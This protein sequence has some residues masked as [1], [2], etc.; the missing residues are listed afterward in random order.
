[1]TL[2]SWVFNF[3]FSLRNKKEITKSILQ[4]CLARFWCTYRNWLMKTWESLMV[5]PATSAITRNIKLR[6]IVEHW[7]IMHFRRVFEWNILKPEFRIKKNLFPFEQVG[8]YCN[9]TFDVCK[10]RDEEIRCCEH[11]FPVYSEHGLCFSF[12]PRYTD[13]ATKEWVLSSFD[14]HSVSHRIHFLI[15]SHVR[16]LNEK[17]HEL[18]ETDKKWALFF[19]PKREAKIFVHSHLENFGWDFR[20]HVIWEP[21]FAA[22]LLISMKQ[23]YTTEDAKQLTIGQRKCIFPDEIKLEFYEG[24]YTFTSC[25]K[26]CR[27]RKCLKFCGCIPPFYRPFRMIYKIFSSFWV[28]IL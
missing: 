24:E 3:P 27:I 19:T 5:N 25:M 13:E 14:L 1:M 21:D 28:S 8:I 10:Y 4:K 26:E 15:F 9:E 20:P 11:F 12:N 7:D 18:F 16:N 23:T 6:S 22:E 2:I 17:Y